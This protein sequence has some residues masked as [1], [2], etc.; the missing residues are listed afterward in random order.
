MR[1]PLLHADFE[2]GS[3]TRIAKALRKVWPRGELSLMQA[4]N[5]LGVLLGYNSQHDAR[6]EAIAAFSIPDGSLAM[7]E[8][9]SA[10]VTQMLLR[11]AIDPVAGRALVSRLHLDELAVASISAEAKMQ[12]LRVSAVQDISGLIGFE[13]PTTSHLFFDEAAYFLVKPNDD[14]R[15][16]L[17]EVDGVPNAS[18]QVRGDRVFV[19]EKLL[20]LVDAVGMKRENPE[21][22]GIVRHLVD[23]ACVTSREAVEQWRLIPE[24][25]ELEPLPGGYLAIRHK[26]FNARVPGVF[27]TTEATWPV[28]TRLLMGEVVPGEGQFEFN[29]QPLT[30]IEPLSLDGLTMAAPVVERAVVA[31]SMWMNLERVE[32]RA[33]FA[34]VPQSLFLKAKETEVAWNHARASMEETAGERVADIWTQAHKLEFERLNGPGD[35][36]MEDEREQVEGL[37]ECYPELS[38]LS[39]ATLWSM[40]DTFQ[41]ECWQMGSWDDPVRDEQFVFFLIGCLGGSADL[42]YSASDRG[43][44]VAYYL[45]HASPLDHALDLVRQV[46]VNIGLVNT[47]ARR[48][49]DAM[50]FVEQD[51]H[52]TDRRGPKVSTFGD[53]FRIGRKSNTGLTT[54]TQT[55]P[56]TGAPGPGLNG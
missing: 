49:A 25:Y 43:R 11:Y 22:S 44:W 2:H 30:L 45:M 55:W 35:T 12:R 18:Y 54:I 17:R 20:R 9:E 10:V 8:I 39:D 42:R 33:G 23:D 1:I 27:A 5:T 34:P 14:L 47:V 15:E 19:F 50:K 41:L 51:A 6:R 4:Q 38:M 32:W 21:F 16:T 3:Y 40:Y 48:I 52:A 36:A 13:K 56:M 26:P 24:P 28:L 46:V 29:A 37:R 7:R 53:M 31:N